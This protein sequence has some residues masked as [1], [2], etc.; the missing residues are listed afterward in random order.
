MGRIENVEEP[1]C[2]TYVQAFFAIVKIDQ[3]NGKKIEQNNVPSGAC[4]SSDIYVLK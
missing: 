1:F 2:E 4:Q 3:G